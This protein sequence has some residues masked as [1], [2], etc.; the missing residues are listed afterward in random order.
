MDFFFIFK[1]CHPKQEFRSISVFLTVT[2]VLAGAKGILLSIAAD[3]FGVP[4]GCQMLWVKNH[5]S[6]Y[7]DIDGDRI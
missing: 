2:G 4:S 7:F 1:K 3:P 5:R 6:S